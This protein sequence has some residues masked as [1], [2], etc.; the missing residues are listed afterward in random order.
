[1]KMI[2]SIDTYAVSIPRDM[3]SKFGGAGSP[4]P[5][6]DRSQRYSL[7]KTYRTVYGTRVET[8]LVK[9]TTS[10]GIYGWGEAQSPVVPE[11]T[12]EIIHGL[13]APLILGLDDASPV[14]VRDSL[15]NAM[16]VRGH[17]GGFYIDALSAVDCA[18]WDIVGK[19]A[20]E[21]V[22]RLLGGP[23]SWQLPTYVSGLTGETL[24]DQ[25]QEFDRL[26]K[27][28]A[29]AVKV[30][31]SSTSDDCLALVAEIRRRS[32][33]VEIFVDA[34]WRLGV[35]EA[36]EFSRELKTSGVE[37][38]EAPLVPEDIEGH[39]QLAQRSRV[40]I[41]IGESYRTGVEILPLLQ[42]RAMEVMQPDIGR[43]GITEA[44]HM[45]SLARAFH[46]GMAPH[47]SIGLG[48]QIAAA[49]HVSACWPHLEVV[50][51]NPRIYS[52]ANTFLASPL[53]FSPHSVGVPAEPGL[54]IDL[55]EPELLRYSK[56]GRTNN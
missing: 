8:M 35:T 52:L 26:M 19:R 5:V 7:A 39:R 32:P 51:C 46:V 56:T 3:V 36:I 22:C 28:G 31:L 10:D 37:W 11:V 2:S 18:L 41:A 43:S 6:H 55:N 17:T 33:S 27:E 24:A 38:L 21:P 34:L 53:R 4:A 13:I 40:R 44:M 49:L 23:I 14:A 12:Q 25:L 54:G 29:R 50:E 45:A 30:F 42:N 20:G 47:I 9:I 48:P 15:Y 1:M 16:R